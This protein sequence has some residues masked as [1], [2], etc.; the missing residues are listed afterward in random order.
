MYKI[1]LSCIIISN[2]IFTVSA[3]PVI[4]SADMP[5]PGDFI[6]RKIIENLTDIDFSSSDENYTWDFSMI[7][8]T[9]NQTDTFVNIYSTPLTY[10]TAFSNPFDLDHFATVASP[11]NTSDSLMGIQMADVYY[12]YKNTSSAFNI[13]GF[14]AKVNGVPLAIKYNPTDKL[15]QF[16]LNFGNIDSSYSEY[17]IDVPLLGYFGEKIYRKNYVDGWGT[18]YLPGDTFSTIR[19]R[20]EVQCKDSIY[21]DSLYFG[22]PFYRYSTEYKWFAENY[23]QPVL[24]ITERFGGMG[25]AGTTGV[26]VDNRNDFHID[27]FE[28]HN[29]CLVYPNPA[30]DMLYVEPAN[31]ELPIQINIFSF[32]GDLVYNLIVKSPKLILDISSFSPGKYLIEIM[33]TDY[34]IY[35]KIM[36]Y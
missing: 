22:F 17:D 24:Q 32:K 3:Q 7:D 35:K 36:I 21:I 2:L 11:Q 28:S 6:Y 8:G 34:I 33:F 13:V 30:K 29:K 10:L 23:T 1:L 16:P 18:L 19:V 20:S 5:S 27:I 26:F 31:E 9:V 4:E 12:F 14:G 25:G 15:L